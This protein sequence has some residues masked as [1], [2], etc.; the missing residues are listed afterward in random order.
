M[1]TQ[2]WGSRCLSRALVEKTLR[3]R[4]E[5]VLKQGWVTLGV[6]QQGRHVR[7]TTWDL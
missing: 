5:L 7:A 1:E 2:L 4:A 3:L 6:T